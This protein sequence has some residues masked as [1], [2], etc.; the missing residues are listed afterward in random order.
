[1]SKVCAPV[2][3]VKIDELR[4]KLGPLT[5]ES[6][7]DI[8]IGIV[9]LLQG[10]KMDMANFSIQSIRPLIKQQQVEYERR[11]MMEYIKQHPTNGLIHTKHWL[12]QSF[13]NL[14]DEQKSVKDSDNPVSPIGPNRILDQAFFHLLNHPP[15]KSETNFYPETVLLDRQKFSELN[16][17]KRNLTKLAGLLIISGGII[18]KLRFTYSQSQGITG[19]IKKDV[20]CLL[21][22]ETTKNSENIKIYIS[23]L[24]EKYKKDGDTLGDKFKA[25]ISE[26]VPVLEDENHRVRIIC[27]KRIIEYIDKVCEH[28]T[29]NQYRLNGNK[30]PIPD[31]PKSLHI[32]SSEV[33]VLAAGFTN[34]VILNKTIHGPFYSGLIKEIYAEFNSKNVET[35]KTAEKTAENT[36]QKDE[37]VFV[38]S[39]TSVSSGSSGSCS[40]ETVSKH[41]AQVVPMTPRKQTELKV[42]NE[43]KSLERSEETEKVRQRC[44]RSLRFDDVD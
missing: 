16:L 14:M 12:T 7:S 9:N 38:E 22:G 44:A 36:V 30:S 5:L 34:L 15:Q 10:M 24:F 29:A 21:E 1:M 3:D 42:L 26:I 19:K 27:K 6:V 4:G 31:I 32:I 39:S 41:V 25:L 28:T 13:Y 18:H 33:A 43:E 11:K 35:E 40:P 20:L 8:F 2:R 17:K 23:D 37:P